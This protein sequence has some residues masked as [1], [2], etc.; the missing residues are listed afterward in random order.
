[1][2][3]RV[4]RYVSAVYIFFSIIR[5]NNNNNN[6]NILIVYEIGKECYQ[7]QRT[8]T[9]ISALNKIKYNAKEQQDVI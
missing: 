1:M 5:K 9:T 6:N 2:T 7:G 8:T 3:A 4:E